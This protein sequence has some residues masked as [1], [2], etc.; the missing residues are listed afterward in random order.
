M[1]ASATLLSVTAV[2]I[3]IASDTPA[4]IDGRRGLFFMGKIISGLGIGAITTTAQTYMSETVP[5]QL[6]GSILPA[7]PIFQ[8]V[9]Q[10]TGSIIIQVM[11]DV[12]GR[13]SYRIT[14][15]TMWA[16]SIMP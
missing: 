16:F 3:F 1:L 7:F 4:N 14:F 11:M 15:A 8:L 2:V 6:R 5:T 10:I 13:N 9:G 12:P